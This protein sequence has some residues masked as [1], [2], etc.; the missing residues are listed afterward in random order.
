[1][2]IDP[3]F[4]EL[5][6]DALDFF[7][8]R[9]KTNGDQHH[10]HCLRPQQHERQQHYFRLFRFMY[11]LYRHGALLACQRAVNLYHDRS[12]SLGNRH[13]SSSLL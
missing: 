5:T 9:K 7:S 13:V 10:H 1:M 12:Y 4:V 11:R 2:S 8:S 3:K 6:I